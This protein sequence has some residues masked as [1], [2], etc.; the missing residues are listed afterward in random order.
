MRSHKERLEKYLI[1]CSLSFKNAYM[2]AK[3]NSKLV[4]SDKGEREEEELY[5]L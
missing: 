3:W 1:S 5:L 2:I 4:Y